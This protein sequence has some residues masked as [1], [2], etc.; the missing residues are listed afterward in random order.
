MR[1]EPKLPDDR[2][3]VS[4]MHPARDAVV[5]VIGVLGVAIVFVVA[6]SVLVDVLVPYFPSTIETKIFSVIDFDGDEVDSDDRDPRHDYVQLLVNRLAGHWEENPYAISISIL[7]QP[8]PNAFAYPGGRIVITSGLLDSVTSESEMAFVLGHEI[9]HFNHR[10]HLRGL[11]R[12]LAIAFALSALSQ[13]GAGGVVDLLTGATGMTS[14][15]FDRQQETAADE[16]GLELVWL[17]YG[18]V[19]GATDFFDHLS[20]S[21]GKI[22]KQFQSYLATHPVHS[23]RIEALRRLADTSGWRRDGATE[24]LAF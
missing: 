2:V 18:H 20:H 1:F 3:N 4:V 8:A 22:E 12:G 5:L 21:S 17:E 10:D 15:H 9:G 6:L 11:G 19:S 23:D 14:R 7:D 24:A 16:I 13:S